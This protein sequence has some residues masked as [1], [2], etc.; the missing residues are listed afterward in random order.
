MPQRPPEPSQTPVAASPAA[1]LR[2]RLARALERED[3]PAVQRLARWQGRVLNGA[4]AR[5]RRE[6]RS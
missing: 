4:L 5:D 2:L 3:W 1:W 6:G